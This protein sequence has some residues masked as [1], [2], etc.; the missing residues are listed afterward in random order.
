[1]TFALNTLLEWRQSLGVPPRS[2]VPF[3]SCFSRMS[4]HSE[5]RRS[6]TFSI[7]SCSWWVWR[8]CCDVAGAGPA[9]RAPHG[10]ATGERN[11]MGPVNMPPNSDLIIDGSLLPVAKYHMGGYNPRF[12]TSEDDVQQLR[13]VRN[14]W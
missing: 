7:S 13:P 10:L 11:E 4:G 8:C 14:T 9:R 6:G 5:D 12:V 1:M 3:C 2:L